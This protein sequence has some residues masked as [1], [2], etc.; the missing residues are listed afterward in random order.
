MIASSSFIGCVLKHLGVRKQPMSDG[1][2]AG[3]N[4]YL[5]HF[6]LIDRINL[7]MYAWIDACMHVCAHSLYIRIFVWLYVAMIV[8]N[9]CSQNHFRIGCK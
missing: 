4:K 5:Q 1:R 8:V 6:A 9:Q 7:C 3:V 2:H